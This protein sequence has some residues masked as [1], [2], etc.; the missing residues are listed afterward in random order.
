MIFS[1]C[2]YH[3]F[4][5]SVNDFIIMRLASVEFGRWLDGLWVSVVRI[6]DTSNGLP[7]LKEYVEFTVKSGSFS[8]D[9]RLT[10]PE[11]LMLI[12]MLNRAIET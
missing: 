4:K 2:S 10:E 1:L 7:D 8:L 12:K 6:T 9:Y 3:V 5:F 11:I